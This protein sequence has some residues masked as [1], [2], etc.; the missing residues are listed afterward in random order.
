LFLKSFNILVISFGKM[1]LLI[2]SLTSR[3]PPLS[4]EP[5]LSRWRFWRKT[6][7]QESSALTKPTLTLPPLK[8]ALDLLPK[9]RL[10]RITE[11]KAASRVTAMTARAAAEVIRVI[12]LTA[13]AAAVRG[14]GAAT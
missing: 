12:A 3:L 7:E 8:T 4:F 11:P 2:H 9:R 6:P 1:F 13:R 14:A 10:P 5:R